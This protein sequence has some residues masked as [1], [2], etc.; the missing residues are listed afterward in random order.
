MT[1]HKPST[2][3]TLKGHIKNFLVPYFGMREVR[4]IRP[5]QIQR[6]LSG[7][8]VAPKTVRNIIATFRMIWK[9]ARSWGYASHDALEGIVLP[10]KDRASRFFFSVEEVQ[11]SESGDRAIPHVL[12]ACGRDGHAI[13]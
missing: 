9:S 5:E 8:T 2:R 13:R 11:R 10:K 7:L 1:Q 3:S 4:D 12:L 6:F